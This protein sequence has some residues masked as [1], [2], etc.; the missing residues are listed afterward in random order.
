[1]QIKAYHPIVY[2]RGYA[3][4]QGEIEETV[5]DPYMGFNLGST[6][7]RQLWDG[8]IKPF[9]F[10]SPLVRLMKEHGYD[11]VYEEGVDQVMD[12]R[13][14]RETVPYRSLVVYRYYEPSSK[15][16]GAGVEPNIDTFAIGLTEL[17]LNLRRRIYPKGSATRIDA[18][19]AKAG[20]LPFE[21]FRVHLVAH[22]MGGLV[23]RSFLQNP[24]LGEETLKQA[25]KTGDRRRIQ[26]LERW[27]EETPEARRLVDKLFTY[28]TPHNGIE[29]RGL[30][31]VPGWL[32]LNGINTFNRN[33]MARYLG[34][35]KSDRIG[36]AVDM[37][38]GF[39]PD[40]LFNLVGTNPG[41]YKVAGGL[42]SRA[43]GE[44][45]DGL[46]RIGNA[47][48]RGRVD[49]RIQVS[50][51]AFVH[52]SHSGHFGIVNSEPG[53]QNLVRFLF[54]DVRADGYLDID[55][56]TLPPAV[57]R[58][59]DAD[60]EVR[61]SYLF[62]VA[63]GIRGKQ[64]QLHRRTADENSAVFRKFDDLFPKRRGARRPNR[65][66]SPL[67]FTVFLD[68]DQSQTGNT[69]AFSVDLCVRV[70]EYQVNGFL[71]LNNHYEGGFLF[72]DM[73]HIEATPPAGSQTAWKVEYQFASRRGD[74]VET[75]TL[76]ENDG[77]LS[78]GIPIGQPQ[79]PGIRGRLRVVTRLW[80]R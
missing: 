65:S 3:M 25:R 15:D 19:E 21:D 43:V 35:K 33:E 46:V 64:W 60:R 76:E 23:C 9:F 49:G 28:A 41:D 44:A 17:I 36:D 18:A 32:S 12:E 73:L 75:A 40:R 55:E 47:V 69:L 16:L 57:Q 26:Q 70:P 56:L 24:A 1:M 22:S 39:D 7:A 34:L 48:T 63:V 4:T 30:G 68:Q 29:V 10:E 13:A 42:S 20:K 11:D 38:T 78:F 62:E 31:N 50:P 61:A 66:E 67:L 8:S 27:Q 77:T 53:Y 59:Y 74:P 5:A 72:R 80:N 58:E 45:S 14:H 71:F 52:R 51:H 79:P 54:G 2:V 6:K 37:V